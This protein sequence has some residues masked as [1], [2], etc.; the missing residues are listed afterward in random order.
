M[1][2]CVRPGPGPKDHGRQLVGAPYPRTISGGS[3]H[4]G[5]L[6]ALACLGS[7][8]QY[9]ISQHTLGPANGT[10]G[11]QSPSKYKTESARHQRRYLPMRCGRNL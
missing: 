5:E 1:L 9:I 10:P 11:P 2:P 4:R 7:M 6:S 3:T 8:Y